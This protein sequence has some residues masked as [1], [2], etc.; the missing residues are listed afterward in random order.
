VRRTDIANA[1]RFLSSRPDAHAKIS[2]AVTLRGVRSPPR[3]AA[4]RESLG[5]DSSVL[6]LVRAVNR[7]AEGIRRKIFLVW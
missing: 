7:L 5:L 6:P 4:P 3:K 2:S 1:L